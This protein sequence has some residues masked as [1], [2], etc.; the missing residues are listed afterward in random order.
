MSESQRKPRAKFKSYPGSIYK[1]ATC[2]TLYIKLGKRRVA[3]GLPDTKENRR[4]AE[5][6]L[7]DLYRDSKG[8]PTRFTPVFEPS[9]PKIPTYH[10]AIEQYRDHLQT[11]D[12]APKTIRSYM[13][14]IDLVISEQGHHVS[15]RDVEMQIRAF[16]RRQT[17]LPAELRYAPSSINIFLR[18]IAAFCTWLSKEKILTE[19]PDVRQ[20]RRKG[21]K[22][23]VRVL[24]DN[25]CDCII[26]H[27]ETRPVDVVQDGIGRWQEFALFLRFLLATGMRRQETLLLSWNNVKSDAIELSHKTLFTPEYFPITREVRQILSELPPPSTERTRIFR[28]RPTTASTLLKYLNE[29]CK[30][31]SLPNTGGFHI[32]RKTF[33]DR[34]KRAGID[35]AD[36]QKL[37]RHKNIRTTIESYTYTDTDR[38]REVLD[39]KDSKQ[40]S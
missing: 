6:L 1:P 38:L 37:L 30:Q 13:E 14:S 18:S 7:W 3:T 24:D 34:L 26:R 5:E 35:M 29:A 39:G 17:E 32:F 23:P 28:W 27:F 12:H 16:I 2:R 8:M 11:T 15:A 19:T 20:F 10:E 21:D 33:Q 31:L 4:I 25:T 36:R 22:K 9:K 40:R